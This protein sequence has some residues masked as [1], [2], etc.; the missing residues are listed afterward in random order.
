MELSTKYLGLKLKNPIIAGASPLT[1][2]LDSIKRLEDNGAAAIVMHSIFEEQIT[3]EGEALEYFLE[4][5]TNSFLESQDFF[6]QISSY[7]N[8][9]ADQYLEEIAKIK[10]SVNIPVIASLN[11]ASSSGWMKY[12]KKIEETGADAIELNIAH[13]PISLDMSAKDVEKLY[14][15]DVKVVR[16]NTKL[17]IS[18][19]MSP[20]LSAPA[21]MAKKFKKA[22]VDGLVL[23][24]R[25][26]LV[27]I[28]LEELRVEQTVNL[29][30][31]HALSESLRWSAILYNQLDLSLCAS[32][33]V[34]THL[35]ILKAI[36]SGADCVQM[37]SALL[38]NKE[39][40]V[41]NV[42]KDLTDWMQEKE[43]ASIKMM[44]GSISHKHADNPGAYERASYMQAL[45]SYR[46]YH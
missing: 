38:A 43:Y 8:A 28:D 33:G 19:K 39:V 10:M 2:N 5:G 36:M 23:F 1:S 32:T 22:G 11:G 14:I 21:N 45:Q 30:D 13:V 7:E 41:Q 27:N 34:H 35:D 4:Q 20:N 44:K 17:P 26:T 18:I 40:H 6:P 9:E 24:D 12:A 31:S 42:L 37:V 46:G 15:K 25:P 29:S 16:E 3:H